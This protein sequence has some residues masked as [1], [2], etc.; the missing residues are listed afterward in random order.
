MDYS[1]KFNE[2]EWS[3]ALRQ[4]GKQHGPACACTTCKPDMEP[5]ERDLAISRNAKFNA[6][7]KLAKAFKVKEML[8]RTTTR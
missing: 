6:P 8:E 5:N 3:L 1:I 4:A 2:R 7:D